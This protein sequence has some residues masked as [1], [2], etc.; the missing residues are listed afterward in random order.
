MAGPSL[1]QPPHPAIPDRIPMRHRPRQPL[2]DAPL[3]LPVAD[4][5]LMLCDI[6]RS[7]NAALGAVPQRLHKQ[8]HHGKAGQAV[9]G[10]WLGDMGQINPTRRKQRLYMAKPVHLAPDDLG[11][12]VQQRRCDGLVQHGG[13]IDDGD[14]L[15]LVRL[16]RKAENTPAGGPANP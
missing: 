16:I 1:G 8:P 9:A 13:R 11:A 14:S 6:P 2:M 3:R 15:C 7:R 10:V 12:Q 5:R 4:I